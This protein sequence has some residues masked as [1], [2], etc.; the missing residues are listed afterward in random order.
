MSRPFPFH[1]EYSSLN[2]IS[3]FCGDGATRLAFTDSARGKVA[4]NNQLESV[5]LQ[6]YRTGVRCSERCLEKPML[7]KI[8]P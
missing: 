1:L 3:L 6:M 4:V 2:S 8:S 7:R 5:V